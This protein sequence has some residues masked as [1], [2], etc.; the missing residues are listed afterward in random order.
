MKE[1]NEKKHRSFT[2][3]LPPKMKRTAEN[4]ANRLHISFSE[5]V[6][7]LLEDDFSSNRI[8]SILQARLAKITGN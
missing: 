7:R 2:V 6:Q 1:E 4:R 5:Y 3:S 8:N